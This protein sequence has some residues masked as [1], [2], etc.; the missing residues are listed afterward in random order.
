MI[1]TDFLVVQQLAI[2]CI[3]AVQLMGC[4]ASESLAQLHAAVV[5]AI[6]AAGEV[7]WAAAVALQI[8]LVCEL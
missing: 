7:S 3:D 1:S 8:L 2:Q 4:E 6:V 5:P